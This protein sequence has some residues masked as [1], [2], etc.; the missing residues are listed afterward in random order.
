MSYAVMA[1]PEEIQRRRARQTEAKKSYKQLKGLGFLG[2]VCTVGLFTPLAPL[3]MVGLAG[4]AVTAGTIMGKFQA[5]ET[6]ENELPMVAAP[7][8]QYVTDFTPPTNIAE[9]IK[10]SRWRNPAPAPT[11]PPIP[12]A[13]KQYSRSV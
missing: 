4:S 8:E 12:S 9:R 13:Y 7:K 2:L 3:A 1:T 5:G 6:L 11:P 10:T